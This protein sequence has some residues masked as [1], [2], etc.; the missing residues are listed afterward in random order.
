MWMFPIAPEENLD[1]LYADLWHVGCQ[2]PCKQLLTH[3]LMYSEYF[4]FIFRIPD[5]RGTEGI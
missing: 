5:S 1:L 4:I 3:L 2:H